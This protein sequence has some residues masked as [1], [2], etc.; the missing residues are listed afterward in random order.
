MEISHKVS[1]FFLSLLLKVQ[2]EAER[3]SDLPVNKKVVTGENGQVQHG[4]R[5]I[6]DRENTENIAL[7]AMLLVMIINFM[8]VGSTVGNVFGSVLQQ[9]IVQVIVLRI[10]VGRRV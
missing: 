2:I 6:I 7:E 9:M 3:I 5:A 10:V 4:E 1:L 8:I